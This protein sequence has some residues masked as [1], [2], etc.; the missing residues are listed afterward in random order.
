M[1]GHGHFLV[2]PDGTQES[3]SSVS[4]A[5]RPSVCLSAAP[6]P[7]ELGSGLERME[8]KGGLGRFWLSGLVETVKPTRGPRGRISTEGWHNSVH[9]LHLVTECSLCAQL[10]AG[11][12]DE[13]MTSLPPFWETKPRTIRNLPWVPLPSQAAAQGERPLGSCR[14]SE[15]KGSSQACV[16]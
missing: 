13:V 15:R 12:G 14:S 2:L 6:G 8:W 4:G 7:A 3:H 10:R 9:S 16:L 5:Q 11:F 1:L